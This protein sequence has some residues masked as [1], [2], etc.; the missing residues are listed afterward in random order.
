MLAKLKA[1][2]AQPYSSGMSAAGWTAMVGLL[3]VSIM[4][5]SMVLKRIET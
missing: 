1:W 4:L 3:L 2:V 5:W